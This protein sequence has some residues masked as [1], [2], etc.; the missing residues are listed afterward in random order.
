MKKRILFLFGMGVL[1][2]VLCFKFFDL[3]GTLAHYQKVNYWYLP[4]FFLACV[5]T[6][7]LRGTRWSYLLKKLVPVRRKEVIQTYMMGSVIDFII[8]LRISEIIKC[9]Y[10]KRRYG[11]SIS[12]VLPT[13]L[14]DKLF[15]VSPIL[16]ILAVMPFVSYQLSSEIYYVVYFLVAVLVAG[17]LFLVF[18]FWHVKLVMRLRR[19][20]HNKKVRKLLGLFLRFVVGYRKLN[21]STLLFLKM[22]ALSLLAIFFN[23]VSFYVCILALGKSIPI[24]VVLFGYTLL[25]LSY[26]APSPPGQMGSNEIVALLI[27]SGMFGFAADMVA[28]VVFFAHFFTV[29]YIVV[30]GLFLLKTFKKE[31]LLALA[32]FGSKSQRG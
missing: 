1:F 12:K 9:N 18:V 20:S 19:G 17:V 14:I 30:M 8:P 7:Y 16:V 32:F 10:I 28:A 5:I 25:F 27:F 2:L 24:L 21:F 3:S 15:D 22:F 31:L 29:L 6:T 13:V 23:C 26:A 4:L 11:L